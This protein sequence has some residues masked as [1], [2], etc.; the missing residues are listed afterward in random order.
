LIEA[1]QQNDETLGRS[2]GPHCEEGGEQ[3]MGHDSTTEVSSS[4]DSY[5]VFVDDNF[6]YM[7]EDE[8]Y[9]AGVFQTYSEALRHA[10]R[11]VD[12]SL[13]DLHEVG[14]SAD[15]LMASYVSFGEDPWIRPTPQGTER[16]SARAYAPQRAH[17]MVTG[18]AAGQS[19]DHSPGR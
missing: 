13:R 8:R 11:I 14:K 16:F 12:K 7:D 9:S 19:T 1:V 17:E 3:I 6:H 4:V 10:K 15:D 5:E 18:S 2:K